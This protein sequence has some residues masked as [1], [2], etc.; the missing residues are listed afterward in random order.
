[1]RTKVIIGS[2]RRVNSMP[3]RSGFYVVALLAVET[4][5]LCGNIAESGAHA[6]AEAI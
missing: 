1:M 4:L 2:F 3:H 6:A 5:L